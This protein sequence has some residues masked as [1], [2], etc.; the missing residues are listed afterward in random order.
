M[1]LCP[2]RCGQLTLVEATRRVMK[3]HSIITHCISRRFRRI[4][5]LYCTD[6]EPAARPVVCL[7][8]HLHVVVCDSVQ[9]C[10]VVCLC[11]YRSVVVPLYVQGADSL[12][13]DPDDAPCESA[14]AGA[15]CGAR[16]LLML[17]VDP[18]FL[19]CCIISF[20]AFYLG[21]STF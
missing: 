17:S 11:R 16:A 13:A 18:R 4:V 5:T 9:V 20:V 6:Q 3:P 10:T 19:F 1:W 21:G 2:S 7:R 8:R 12:A 15:K 14:I